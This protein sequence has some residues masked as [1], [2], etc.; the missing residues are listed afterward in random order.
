MA[1][2]FFPRAILTI[3]WR[4]SGSVQLR[5]AKDLYTYFNRARLFS[6]LYKYCMCLLGNKNL[7]GCSVIPITKKGWFG[8]KLFKI[9]RCD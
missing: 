4:G 6:I 7:K 8:L 2:G 1:L 9:L 3:N 5:Q